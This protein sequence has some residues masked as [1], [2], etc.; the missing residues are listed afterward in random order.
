MKIKKGFT[1]IELM[2]TL[3]IMAILS[4]I[5]VPRITGYV[6]K[7]KKT[8]AITI[9]KQLQMAALWSYSEM[10]NSFDVSNLVETTKLVTG[11][12][13]ISASSIKSI[14]SKSVSIEY[15]CESKIYSLCINMD[16]SSFIIWEGSTNI[17]SGN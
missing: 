12:Q 4:S 9:G 5:A 16:N 2:V 1:L 15:S 13:S 6:E 14:T 7:A 17:F 3:S 10:G 8:K 11:I